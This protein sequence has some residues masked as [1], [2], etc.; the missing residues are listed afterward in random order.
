MVR[1]QRCGA[2]A[3][4]AAES[5]YRMAAGCCDFSR[6]ANRTG[7]RSWRFSKA[8]RPAC[9]SISTPSH[10]TC[11][12][13]RAGTDAD[14]AWPSNPTAPRSCRACGAG[15]RRAGRSR[16]SSRT[17][18]GRTGSARWR[19]APE[20][21][22]DATGANRAP[23]TRPRPGHADLAGA[24][25][26]ELDDI[27]DVLE[28]ASAR[29]TAA[30]VATAGLARQLL[31]AFDIEVLSHVVRIGDVA[32]PEALA[33][34]VSRIRAIPADSPLHCADP[35]IEPQMIAA[36]DAAREAGDTLGG[37]FEVVVSGVPRG[38]WQLRAV[39]SQ[40]R[41]AAGAGAHVD[42]GDQG[43]GHREGARGRRAARARASTTR[44]SRSRQR[45]R[46]TRR[47]GSRA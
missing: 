46:G 38:S 24:L 39:G 14:A 13:A 44:S 19:S 37:A 1:G 32:I 40:A 41:W 31:A 9:R 27:R 45:R 16:C 23:V 20:A 11:V 36:I 47:S 7:R 42:P 6:R 26:Y 2:R 43:R 5:S 18:T 28:R 33:V 12:A 29:E 25:K 21:P 17:R 34:P 35:A 30:R 15:T 4:E 10:A 22:A 8:C 3:P